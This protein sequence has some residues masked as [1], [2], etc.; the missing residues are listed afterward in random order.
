M[1][2]SA[3]PKTAFTDARF[4]AMPMAALEKKQ[5]AAT[6]LKAV[7]AAYMCLKCISITFM[8]GYDLLKCIIGL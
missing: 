8:L 3:K 5:T 6:S 2:Q 4:K 7:L 1:L